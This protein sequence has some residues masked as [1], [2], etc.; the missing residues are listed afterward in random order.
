MHP[1]GIALGVACVA[2]VVLYLAKGNE[3][4]P[5][6]RPNYALVFFACAALAFGVVWMFTP[7]GQSGGGGGLSGNTAVVMKEIEIGEPDF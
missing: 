2:V 6:K 3:A 1:L 7:D 5:D 4:D